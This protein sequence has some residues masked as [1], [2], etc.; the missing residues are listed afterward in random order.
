M[1]LSRPDV[2]EGGT[3]SPLQRAK[4]DVLFAL[5]TLALG[6]GRALPARSLATLGRSLGR[7]A[8]ALAVGARRTARDN[9]ARA[10]PDLPRAEQAELVRR[11]FLTL[12][13]LLGQTVAS[14]HDADGGG[15][16]EVTPDARD[17][18]HE[19]LAV[20]RGVIFPSAHLGPWELV[21]RS[22]VRAGI[23]LVT[24]ARESYDPRFARLYAQ[25]RESHGIGVVWRATPGAAARIVK[26]LRS[27][28]VLGAPMD[29]RS[30]V[31]SCDVPFLGH[32]A[33]TPAGPA[34][35]ALRT[36]APVV[37]GTAAP[38]GVA[39]WVVTATRIPTSDLRADAEG[40]T[41]LT[42]RINAELSRR[43]RDLPHAWV[44]MHERWPR[45]VSAGV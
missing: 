15:L 18:L 17:T 45:A 40:T 8:H 11:C 42:A 33:P 44:W 37:V 14:L 1:S 21:A 28:R 20:G 38:G 34:R 36:G 35:L 5:A 2:R 13:E 12:G 24:L 19:A 27:G 16:L 7:L 39:R 23:P 10:F 41:E 25:L 22:L 3:W 9:V 29:L 43:I 32:P 31:P 6:A 4:N 30:R 26:T